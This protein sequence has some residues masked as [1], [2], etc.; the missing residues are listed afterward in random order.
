MTWLAKL[1]GIQWNQEF[2]LTVEGLR[3]C[4]AAHSSLQWAVL[5]LALW[6]SW[7]NKQTYCRLVNTSELGMKTC[8]ISN[9]HI[10]PQNRPIRLMSFSSMCK[11]ARSRLKSCSRRQTRQI[12]LSTILQTAVRVWVPALTK[13]RLRS[14]LMPSLAPHLHS[15]CNVRSNFSKRFLLVR[16]SLGW[17]YNSDNTMVCISG[18]IYHLDMI[19][20]ISAPHGCHHEKCCS[21]HP[22]HIIVLLPLLKVIKLRKGTSWQCKAYVNV[23]CIY[24]TTSYKHSINTWRYQYFQYELTHSAFAG[25]VCTVHWS[26]FLSSCWRGVP[27]CWHT[28]HHLVPATPAAETLLPRPCLSTVEPDEISAWYHNL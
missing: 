28:S 18:P 11:V 10:D 17:I 24:C 19:F 23:F 7:T 16:T 13:C 27:C 9:F 4:W 3:R 8:Q 21:A 6:Q 5:S 26:P 25:V 12:T 2:L 1:L 22:V 20:N 15:S 14:L